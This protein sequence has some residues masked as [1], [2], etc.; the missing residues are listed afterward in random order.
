MLE[1]NRKVFDLWNN[2]VSYCHWK[3]NEHIDEGLMGL[4]DMDIL[5]DEQDSVEAKRLLIES[6]YRQF[7]STKGTTYPY[8]EEWLGYDVPTGKMSYIHLHFRI[9][10][11]QAYNKEYCFPWDQY[12]LNSRVFDPER[13][14]YVACPESEIIVLYTRIV[15]KSSDFHS[16]APSPDYKKE[17]DYLKTRIDFAKLNEAC[18][19]M[20]VKNGDAVYEVIKKESLNATDWYDLSRII[21]PEFKQYRTRNRFS[22][23]FR[24]NFYSFYYRFRRRIKAKF[25][26]P[27]I[28]RKTYKNRGVSIC[29]IGA[30]GAGKS[31]VS[32]SIMEFINWKLDGMSFYLGSGDNYKSV[33]KTV[34]HKAY[35][36]NS[37][38]KKN[39]LKGKDRKSIFAKTARFFF[40]IFRAFECINIAKRAYKNLKRASRFVC[41]GGI[42]I[43]D[44]FPQCQFEGIYDGPKI[45]KYSHEYSNNPLFKLLVRKEKAIIL[46]CSR[47]YPDIVFKLLLSPEESMKRK[48][49]HD[50]NEIKVKSDITE[51]LEFPNS[52]VVN[53]DATMPYEEELKLIKSHIWTRIIA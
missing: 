45:D 21:V 30:D 16:I 40:H 12:V 31:S 28:T 6:G 8:V 27:I 52:I 53:V 19:T 10:T 37:G 14:T 17:I 29:F 38:S 5:V 2:N 39:E 35:Q 46:K 32:K 36:V 26:L 43:Y 42:A 24:K 48:P 22:T 13:L 23:L 25:N 49:D 50:Y 44:R 4:T 20:F 11:G 51:K 41:H 15:L 47:F 1:I 9:I 34:I 33:S 3:S 7:C 18:K